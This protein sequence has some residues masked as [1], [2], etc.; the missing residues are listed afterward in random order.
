ML[1]LLAVVSLT[2]VWGQTTPSMRSKYLTSL[3]NAKIESYLKHNDFI[4]IPVGTVEVHGGLLLTRIRCSRGL[5]IEDGRGDGWTRPA[6]PHL[7]LPRRNTGWKGDPVV[8]PSDG[9]AYLKN[10]AH[11]LLRQGFRRQIYV[12]LHGPSFEML[13][14]FIREF[15][16]Q[17]K[18]PI[19][20]IDAIQLVQK[21]KADFSRS[22][23][24]HIRW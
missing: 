9:L 7:L 21:N 15:F 18:D 16:D 4:F 22:L 10:I 17:T 8:T 23:L 2:P 20:Y 12:S 3:T 19:L 1:V 5:R 24:A 13:S 6:T 14:P 11:S